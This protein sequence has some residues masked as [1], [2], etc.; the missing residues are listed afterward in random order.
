MLLNSFGYFLSVLG[1]HKTNFMFFLS[2]SNAD[3]INF[4]CFQVWIIWI[5]LF[6]YFPR[7]K[8][9]DVSCIDDKF[10]TFLRYKFCMIQTYTILFLCIVF[11][12]TKIL[13]ISRKGNFMTFLLLMFAVFVCFLRKCLCL[14]VFVLV[15]PQIN[16]T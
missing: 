5:F 2:D 8:F 14:S 16:L 7:I 9:S 13:R 4:V 12:N 15:R 10:V 11:P 3:K 6:V 1:I